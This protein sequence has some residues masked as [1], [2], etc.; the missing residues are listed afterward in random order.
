[1]MVRMRKLARGLGVPGVLGLAILAGSGAFYWLDIVP[2]EAELGA[3]RAAVEQ[4]RKRP[5]LASPTMRRE[6]ELRQFRETFPPLANLAD[7]LELLHTLA[8]RAGIR[9]QQTEFRLEADPS[10][11]AAYRVSLPVR[12]RYPQIRE[13][14]GAV[15]KQCP[16]ASLDRV[17]FQRDK[18]ANAE[19]EA[20]LRLTFY[21]RADEAMKP[22]APNRDEV[23]PGA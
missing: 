14:I 4:T 7:Q 5:L 2:A 6:Q 21:F 12:G 3:R 9:V 13:F 11:L 1:M 10:G 22:P 17:R 20:Q 15:L 16:T 19:I 8:S 23:I 18:V